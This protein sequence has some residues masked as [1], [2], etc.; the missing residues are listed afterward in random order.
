MCRIHLLSTMLLAMFLLAGCSQQDGLFGSEALGPATWANLEKT[1]SGEA[2]AAA[3]RA[4]QQEYNIESRDPENSK[5]LAISSLYL[6]RASAGTLR[7][8]LTNPKDTLRRVV[9]LQISRDRLGRTV[10]RVRVEVQRRDTGQMRAFAY[11]RR[12]SDLPAVT[13]IEQESPAGADK[14]TVWTTIRRDRPSEQQ[15]IEIIKT[16]LGLT[17]T[18][19]AG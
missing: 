1:G 15:I 4:V 12:R 19:A 13:P 3:Q 17:T 18:A 9:H 14:T 11:Q 8:G 5:L 6:S 16:Q 7:E 2:F 10:V